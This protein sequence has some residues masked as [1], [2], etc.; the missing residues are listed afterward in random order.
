M[1]IKQ[2]KCH[3]CKKKIEGMNDQN[4]KKRYN[5]HLINEHGIHIQHISWDGDTIKIHKKEIVK[6]YTKNPAKQHK[7]EVAL[8]PQDIKSK[9]EQDS[10]NSMSKD[11]LLDYSAKHGMEK[12]IKYSMN[13]RT[14][15]KVIRSI[16]SKKK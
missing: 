11:E 16:L 5:L 9:P 2:K 4:F 13:K 7:T 6:E 8:K 15:M 14:I 10:I 1:E 12:E 3:I